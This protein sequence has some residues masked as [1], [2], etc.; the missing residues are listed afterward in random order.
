MSS[1]LLLRDSKIDAAELART[2]LP[3]DELVLSACS[4]GWRP[5]EIDNVVLNADEILAIPGGVL[6]SGV[7]SVLLSIPR[8][9]GK[10]ASMLTAHYHQRRAA[11]D[12]P[13]FAFQSAQQHLLS[14]NK[15]KFFP[16]QWIGFTLYGCV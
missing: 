2:R 3:F 7:S 15:Q 11:G 6:E 5:T 16:G 13:L 14:Q 8:S 12:S 10:S 4:T 1:G 9:E